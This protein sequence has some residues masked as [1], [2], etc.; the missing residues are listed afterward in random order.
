[1]S[2]DRVILTAT[3]ANLTPAQAV[4]VQAM[5]EYW[6]YLGAIGSSRHVSFMA[7]GDGNF[8]PK[9]KVSFDNS[10]WGDKSP[11]ECERLKALAL[12]RQEPPAFDFDPVAWELRK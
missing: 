2:D 6:Q 7:D 9:V 4:A 5:L 11:E 12:V 1:M 8:R 3:I 10:P